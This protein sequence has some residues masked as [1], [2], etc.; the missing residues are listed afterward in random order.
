MDDLKRNI[1]RY[2]EVAR[3]LHRHRQI[4]PF[5][6]EEICCDAVHESVALKHNHI[7]NDLAHIIMLTEL[8]SKQPD[9]FD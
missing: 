7:F 3:K 5:G 1:S 2:R 6:A 8:L 4:S 9:L